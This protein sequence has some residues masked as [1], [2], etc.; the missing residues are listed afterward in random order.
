[1]RMCQH[2][3]PDSL[4]W[5]YF[6]FLPFA[7]MGFASMGEHLIFDIFKTDFHNTN[8]LVGKT[9]SDFGRNV[10]MLWPMSQKRAFLFPWSTPKSVT[11]LR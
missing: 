3:C 7:S 4:G 8:I 1:M 9:G 10:C 11:F 5:E 6:P 2:C